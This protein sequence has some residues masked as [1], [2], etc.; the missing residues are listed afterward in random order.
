MLEKGLNER[1][2]LVEPRRHRSCALPW[3]SSQC[4]AMTCAR[5]ARPSV[6]N[7]MRKWQNHKRACDPIGFNVIAQEPA[8]SPGGADT[9]RFAWITPSPACERTLTSQVDPTLGAQAEEGRLAGGPLYSIA[10]SSGRQLRP[11]T[12][13]VA[14]PLKLGT[15]R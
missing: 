5:A 2:D 13:T 1:V 9:L 10:R 6:Q 11:S 12:H 8:S 15:V 4:T 7:N 3:L 14:R